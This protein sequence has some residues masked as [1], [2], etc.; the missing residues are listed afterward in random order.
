MI[1]STDLTP[2]FLAETIN[3]IIDV[4]SCTPHK[5]VQVVTPKEA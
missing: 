5:D 2:Q 4:H 1:H 3:C